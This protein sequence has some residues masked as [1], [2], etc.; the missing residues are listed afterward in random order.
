MCLENCKKVMFKNT[1]KSQVA[2]KRKALSERIHNYNHQN[3]RC[4]HGC[5]LSQFIQETPGYATNLL[6]YCMGHKISQTTAHLDLL[7]KKI[8]IFISSSFSLNWKKVGFDIDVMVP[9][10]MHLLQSLLKKPFP[11]GK[12]IAS[13]W[14][15]QKLTTPRNTLSTPQ[16]RLSHTDVHNWGWTSR[17]PILARL[18]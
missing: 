11:H 13:F 8:N 3:W 16:E 12:Y 5:R 17:L 10:S 4:R 18:E 15:G 9:G 14:T 7:S 1:I 6:V 2:S